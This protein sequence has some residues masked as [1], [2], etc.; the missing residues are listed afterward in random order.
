MT[1]GRSSKGKTQDSDSWNVGSIPTL[2]A[3]VARVQLEYLIPA[4]EMVKLVFCIHEN[5]QAVL[6]WLLKKEIKKIVAEPRV[7][8]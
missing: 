6:F 1:L 8:S 7:F 5:I 3:S 4:D 2:P